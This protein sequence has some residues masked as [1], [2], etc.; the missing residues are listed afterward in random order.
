MKIKI[1]LKLIRIIV[2]NRNPKTYLCSNYDNAQQQVLKTLLPNIAT[3]SPT[4]QDC[5]K[6]R[7]SHTFSNIKSKGSHSFQVLLQ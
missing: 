2:Q 6:Q 4:Q 3:T 1:V 5:Q 7:P